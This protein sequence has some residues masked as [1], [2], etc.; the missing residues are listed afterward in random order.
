M[1]KP[2]A[3][4]EFV[5]DMINEHKFCVAMCQKLFMVSN[6]TMYYRPVA[7]HHLG[8]KWLKLNPKPAIIDQELP[9]KRKKT[10]SLM[11]MEELLATQCC[12]QKPRCT[13]RLHV[14]YMSHFREA[15]QTANQVTGLHFILSLYFFLF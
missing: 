6:N 5:G 10:K 3:F 14:S 12:K 2:A 15:Y 8:G 11:S 1:A 9:L 4:H 7:A 13:Q